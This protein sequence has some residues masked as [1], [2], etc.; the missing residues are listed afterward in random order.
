MLK[1][2]RRIRQNLVAE[3]KF[4]NY[5]LYGIGEIVLVVIG[6]LIALQIN[7]W[8]QEQDNRKSE[9]GYL[10][11]FDRDLKTELI[12]LDR[13]IGDLNAQLSSLDSCLYYL[14]MKEIEKRESIAEGLRQ[15]SQINNV[16]PTRA[17][18]T[19]FTA[20]GDA[21]I[22][23]NRELINKLYSYYELM[24]T[25]TSNLVGSNREYSRNTFMPYVMGLI[26]FDEGAYKF[27]TRQLNL[28]ELATDSFMISALGIK[29]AIAGSQLSNYEILRNQAQE[30]RELISSEIE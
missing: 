12:N 13:E 16:I 14:S 3:K 8:K 26:P 30:L 28:E 2:F 20:S 24:E 25:T 23:R 6:I 7:S 5:L 11:R 29:I 15:L 1:F 4:S 22:I 9:V 21:K 18:F 19:E 27:E 17:A 10:Q